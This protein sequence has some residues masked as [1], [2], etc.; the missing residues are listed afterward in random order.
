[1]M[2]DR[3]Y[4]IIIVPHT[5]AN[6]RKLQVTARFIS[7]VFIGFATLLLAGL[8]TMIHYVQLFKESANFQRTQEENV[9]L[10]ASLEKSTLLT[11]KLN[12]K[13]SFLTDVSNKLR[14]MAGLPSIGMNNKFSQL[15]P[16]L[17]GTTMSTANGGPDPARL[18]ALSQR[19]D[20]LEQSFSILNKYFQKQNAALST[21]PSILPTEGFI[22]STFGSRRDPFTNAPDFHEGLDLTNVI[23][24]PVVAPADGVVT[25]TGQKGNYGNVIEIKHDDEVSTLYGHLNKIEVHVGDHVKRWQEIGLIGNTGHSTGPHL[26]YEVHVNDQPVNPLPYILN[27]D[28]LEG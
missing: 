12:K 27:L 17:G 19:A 21:T 11:Q 24:T 8:G 5:S 16:G 18:L 9:Q 2:M 13:I 28:S 7:Y 25:F 23:G 14:V 22:S 10:K 15:Q 1:M 26:H 20:Y 6:P 3:R 4:T